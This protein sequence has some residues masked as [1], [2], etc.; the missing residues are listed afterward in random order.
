MTQLSG[1]VYTRRLL[2]ALAVYVVILV[3]SLLLVDDGMG[4]PWR[5]V[6]SLLPVLPMAYVVWLVVA[7][8]RGLDEYWQQVQL[9][10]LPFAF[11]SSL[12][13]LFTWG[14]VENAGFEPLGG[15]VWFGVMVAL[16]LV[17]L[18]I[19]RRRYS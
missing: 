9:M 8:F 4:Q 14:F 19:A 13:L 15:F 12:L 18:W 10:A 7:R 17:G 16:Y 5:T 6:V 1:S 2:G 3:G 11:L